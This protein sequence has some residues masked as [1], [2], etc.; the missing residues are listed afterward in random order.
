MQKEPGAAVVLTRCTDGRCTAAGGGAAKSGGGERGRTSGSCCEGG[1]RRVRA[2]VKRGGEG[3]A[4][5]AANSVAMPPRLA[6]G[7]GRGAETVGV[8]D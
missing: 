1:R 4:T 6:N 5:L 8:G 3:C 7:R 2:G